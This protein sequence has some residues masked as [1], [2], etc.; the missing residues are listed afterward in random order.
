MQVYTLFITISTWLDVL[1]KHVVYSKHIKEDVLC[2]AS[3]QKSVN[4]LGWEVIGRS[5]D[6]AGIVDYHCLNFLP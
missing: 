3:N 2:S 6:I 4:G 1:H 5:V